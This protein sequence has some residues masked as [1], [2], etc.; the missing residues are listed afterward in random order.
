MVCQTRANAL[1]SSTSPNLFYTH[2]CG[3]VYRKETK[4]DSYPVRGLS[5]SEMRETE[6]DKED[7][8]LI[9]PK[10]LFSGTCGESG[11]RGGALVPS[12]LGAGGLQ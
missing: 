7:E 10:S 9:L 5:S 2:H 3:T 1:R 11:L 12:R 8:E 4:R 6:R